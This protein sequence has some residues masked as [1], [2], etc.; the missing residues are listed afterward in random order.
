MGRDPYWNHNVHYHRAVLAAV[1]HGCRT[2]LDAGCGDGLLA[3]KL[4][5]RAEAVT[6]IDRSPEMIRRA[7]ARQPAN[8]T[9]VTGDYLDGTALT[10]DGYDFVSAVAVVHHAPFEDALAAL[11]RLV[12]PGGR[13]VIVG[14]A[15]NH[16]R[17]DWLIS[18]CGLPASRLLARLRGGKRDPDGMPLAH[19]PLHWGEVR[20]AAR[21][22]LPGCHYRR[23]L[24]WRYVV[25]WDKP[26]V[27]W[28]KPVVGWD[29]PRESGP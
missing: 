9:Y 2:A 29:E 21:R 18:A 28:D 24:L 20:A 12:T 25:V 11:T 3:R 1:P 4:A 6:G 13:L 16:T 26:G 27:V 22:L 5:T 19:P 10:E 8:V 14:L 7:R 23:R 15:R 17:L